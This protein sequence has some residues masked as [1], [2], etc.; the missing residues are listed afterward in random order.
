MARAAGESMPRDRPWSGSCPVDDLSRSAAQRPSD[1][2]VPGHQR[3]AAAWVRASRRKRAK[4]ATRLVLREL[5][6]QFAGEVVTGTDRRPA[7]DQL[8]R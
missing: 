3:A 7:E 2:H 5:V 8:P 4:L 1:G 6:E